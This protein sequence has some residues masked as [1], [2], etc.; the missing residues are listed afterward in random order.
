MAFRIVIIALVLGFAPGFR[1]LAAQGT[2]PEADAGATF[3][4]ELEVLLEVG[5]VD[6]EIVAHADGRGW[7]EVISQRDFARLDRLEPGPAL[8][9][10]LLARM[11]G[12]P[13]LPSVRR[14][15]QPAEA[16]RDDR[17]RASFLAP[18]EWTL[19]AHDR[20]HRL[21]LHPG[22]QVGE[23]FAEPRLFVWLEDAPGEAR[24]HHARGY[25]RLALD[26]LG[27]ELGDQGITL[28][29]ALEESLALPRESTAAPLFDVV[30]QIESSARR[31]RLLLATRVDPTHRL[32]IV[33]GLVA[34]LKGERDD[35]PEAPRDLLARVLDSLEFHPLG[36]APTGD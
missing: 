36:T 13:A 4:H 5:V 2:M 27:S 28:G 18:R 7:P 21:D 3:L 20:G 29:T 12:G 15:Y 23:W 32:V 26:L 24:A 19:S 35:L 30:G 1:P 17:L 25:G 10:R 34:P 22:R 14:G 11:E 31:G 6:E 33:V 16:I 9:A 8:R